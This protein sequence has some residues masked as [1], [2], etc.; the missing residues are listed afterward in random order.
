VI[1]LALCLFLCLTPATAAAEDLGHALDIGSSSGEYAKDTSFSSFPTTSLTI[2][3]WAKT[4]SSEGRILSWWYKKSSDIKARDNGFVITTTSSG[5]RISLDC[6]NDAFTGDDCQDQREHTFSNGITDGEWHHVAI[7]WRSSDGRLQYYKDGTL[8]ST[9]T[10]EAKGDSLK[11]SG[12]L[13][14]GQDQDTQGG[15]FE[16][17]QRYIGRL[18]EVRIWNGILSSSTISAWKDKEVDST[19]PNIGSLRSYYKFNRAKGTS[20]A[21]HDGSNHLSMGGMD[22]DRDWVG[23]RPHD[24]PPDNIP[25]LTFTTY[26]ADTALTQG[27]DASVADLDGDG[28][29]DLLATSYSK[30]K[31]YWYKNNGGAAPSFTRAEVGSANGPYSAQAADVDRDGDLDVVVASKN[32]D[33]IAWYKSDGAAT[34]SFTEQTIT[35]SADG[36]TFAYAADIDGDGDMDVLATSMNDDTIAWY[37]NDGS[38]SFTKQTITTSADVASRAEVVDLDQDGDVDVLAASE[39]DDTIAWYKSDGAATPSFTKQ[40]I[41]TS[42]DGATDVRAADMDDDGDLDVLAVSKND[43]TVAWYENDGSQTFTRQVITE[44]ADGARRVTPTDVDGDGDLDVITA[45]DDDE[46]M[47]WYENDGAFDP[48]FTE[49]VLTRAPGDRYRVYLQ[50]VHGTREGGQC[51]VC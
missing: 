39:N 43:D 19:H 21:D 2:E 41:S 10:N 36:A 27:V 33:T 46:T 12:S 24:G 26:K 11:S 37:K 42:A 32:D 25:L 6:Y 45:S 48:L 1:S 29:L 44:S 50:L 28:D 49:H 31:V 9:K 35:T 34:P 15:G 18:D 8:K 38:Q 13:V 30:D 3:F 40:I 23:S 7:T 47:A 22:A 14:L 16:S 20:V 4:K 17:A 51:Q 5:L